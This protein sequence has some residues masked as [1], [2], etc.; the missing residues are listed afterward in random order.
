MSANVTFIGLG[1]MGYPMAGHLARAGHKV[2][3]FNRTTSKAHDWVEEYDGHA[4]DTIAEAVAEADFV[5]TCV[6]ADP[7]LRDVYLSDNGIIDNA[8]AHAILI[9][10]TTVSAEVT[11]EI[12][13][14]ALKRGQGFMDAPV[15]GGQQGAENGKLTIMCGA[16]QQTFDQAKPLLDLY[17]K[18]VTRMGEPGKG[19]LTK[20]VNQIAIAGL[21][22]GLS[23][24]LYFAE[25]SGLD[26]EQVI[27]VISQ[28][29]AQSWQMENRSATMIADKYDHGFA[30]NWM[31]K[32]LDICLTE[33]RQRGITLPVTALVD[34]FYADV[35][36]MGGGR[37]DTSSLLARLR[38]LGNLQ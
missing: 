11:V 29:A 24:C 6:G 15:S 8:P 21:V 17:G 1:V 32:D 33:A 36:A 26:Q 22:Q 12:A 37:W 34:Q 19:Q 7:D 13:E 25:Q 30:V 4:C 9:D 3:V 35:E 27:E 23:E 2:T 14:A 10:H 20:M 16:S 18:A 38:K 31:R 28:G 5:M